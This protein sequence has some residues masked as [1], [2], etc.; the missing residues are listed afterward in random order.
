[1]RKGTEQHH[2]EGPQAPLHDVAEGEKE[3]DDADQ[4]G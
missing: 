2:G 4:A 3:T 1:M